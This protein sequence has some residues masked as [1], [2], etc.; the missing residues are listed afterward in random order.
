MRPLCVKLQD[1]TEQDLALLEKVRQFV[2][3]LPEGPEPNGL[4][5]HQ[6]CAAVCRQF[7]GQFVHW[8]GKFHHGWDHSWLVPT[9]NKFLIMDP[10]PWACASGPILVTLDGFTPWQ[11]LYD[12]VPVGI[13]E[14]G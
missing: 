8:K 10:Y 4:T 2:G 6:V 3:S 7:P 1:M 12:G 11:L 5:C 13:A 9:H 14:E